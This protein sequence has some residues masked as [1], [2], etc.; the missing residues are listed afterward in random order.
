KL[1]AVF[2]VWRSIPGLV[3]LNP[4]TRT[5][6]KAGPSLR[7]PII[8]VGVTIRTGLQNLIFAVIVIIA[9]HGL[10]IRLRSGVG[11]RCRLIRLRLV[12][13][14][15]HCLIRPRLAVRRHS[16]LVTVGL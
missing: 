4:L 9:Q 8:V 5:I 16:W 3:A 11:R 6:R 15:G 12:I 7:L 14:G 10:L 2:A 13:G 1:A